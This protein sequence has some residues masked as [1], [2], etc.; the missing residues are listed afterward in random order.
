M[1]RQWK[2]KICECIKHYTSF[3]KFPSGNICPLVVHLF[4]VLVI[5]FEVKFNFRVFLYFLQ[6]KLMY[7]WL[8]LSELKAKRI[9]VWLWILKQS[10]PLCCFSLLNMLNGFG[11]IKVRTYIL[12]SLLSHHTTTDFHFVWLV[13][14]LIDGWVNCLR[15]WIALVVAV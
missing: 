5:G 4:H 1:H 11:F 3:F 6:Y 8:K 2:K 7:L 13:F 9:V 12:L 14:C 15:W 10:F